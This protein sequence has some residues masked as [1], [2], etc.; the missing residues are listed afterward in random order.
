MV[1]VQVIAPWPDTDAVSVA[2]RD[3]T[4][5]IHESGAADGSQGGIFGGEYGYGANYENDVFLMHRYCWCER[6]SCP[7]CGGCQCPESAWTY[8][9]DGRVVT[10][11]EYS[12]FY[13]ER[14]YG[15]GKSFHD[16]IGSDETASARRERKRRSAEANRRRKTE[17]TPE[18][19][20]CLRRGIWATYAI[21]DGHTGAP[22]FWHKASGLQVRWYKYIGRSM[23]V[24]APPGCVL[25]DI[26]AECIASL[27][28][29]QAVS[30]DSDGSLSKG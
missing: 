15:A 20:Y 19:D 25:A 2:L 24:T 7:W 17:H 6:E 14:V 18:C 1:D 21:P 22:H 16:W 9:V 26:M 4:R 10:Y 28:R 11:E 29:Q 23:E 13:D 12:R 30:K 8:T 3:L 5:A 27:P